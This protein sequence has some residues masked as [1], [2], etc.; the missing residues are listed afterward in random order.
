MTGKA[1]GR[2]YEDGSASTPPEMRWLW[3]VVIY[4]PPV[5]GIVTSGK[6]LTLAVAKT[7][8]ESAWKQWLPGLIISCAR[9][10]GRGLIN[11]QS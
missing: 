4:V 3:S 6:A 2:I 11:A 8:F 7:Q 5:A 10:L 9:G 1:V